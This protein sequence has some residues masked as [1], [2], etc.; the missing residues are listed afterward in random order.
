MSLEVFCNG[1]YYKYKAN[2]YRD[3][4]TIHTDIKCSNKINSVLL[5]SCDPRINID[6]IIYTANIYFEDGLDDPS[7]FGYLE[8]KCFLSYS[9]KDILNIPLDITTNNDKIL[10]FTIHIPKNNRLFLREIFYMNKESIEGN[11]PI[12]FEHKS[13]Y[14]LHNKIHECCLSCILQFQTNK[15]PICRKEL[16]WTV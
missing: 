4:V 15:C 2:W 12:C 3:E 9:E 8:T 14:Y 16:E 5:Y 10:Q 6:N 13:L 1:I 7:I 11:C